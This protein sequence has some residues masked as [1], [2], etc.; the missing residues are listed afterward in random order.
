[1]RFPWRSRTSEPEDN[2]DAE[3]RHHLEMLA[4]ERDGAPDSD[5]YARRKLG[6]T[7]CWV[8]APVCSAHTLS[9]AI[10]LR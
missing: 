3:L 8:S 2:L 6:Y 4:E 5:T 9:P 1:M 7:G 10:W